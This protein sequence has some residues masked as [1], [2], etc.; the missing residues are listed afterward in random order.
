MRPLRS[1]T[2]RDEGLLPPPLAPA[3]PFLDCGLVNPGESCSCIGPP[4]RLFRRVLFVLTR[5]DG[6]REKLLAL[7][8]PAPPAR[9]AVHTGFRLLQRA[10]NA[11]TL[12]GRGADGLHTGGGAEEA[13]AEAEALEGGGGALTAAD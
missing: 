3:P 2:S 10:S 6:R 12:G 13:E 1:C 5:S 9:L 8:P 7:R 11:A 4:F